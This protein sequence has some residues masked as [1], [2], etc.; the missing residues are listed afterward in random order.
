MKKLKNNNTEITPIGYGGA[1]NVSE[2][3]SS[4][5][6]KNG[7][8]NI[9]LDCGYS[10]YSEL[11]LMEEINE[12][13]YVYITHMHD[14]HFGSLSTL[15]FSRFYIN[16]M[17]TNILCSKEMENNLLT[18][19][20]DVIGHDKDQFT[21]NDL[22]DD[23]ILLVMPID[24]TNHHVKN[25][26]SSGVILAFNDTDLV[27]FSGDVNK[28]ILDILKETDKD[29]FDYLLTEKKNVIIL[30]EAT[31]SDYDGN[32]HCNYEKL[33]ETQNL[34]SD[35]YVYHHSKDEAKVIQTESKLKTLI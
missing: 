11:T 26:V 29:F 20:V 14:D 9:L 23:K 32:V 1:F 30:H 18:Y 15:I 19:L 25:M 34:F 7:D 13:D 24:T 2:K 5:L 33:N 35:V 3:N 28:P 22:D 21:L 31:T 16:G 8:V 4:F 17:K 12:I 6:V 10:V 27:L